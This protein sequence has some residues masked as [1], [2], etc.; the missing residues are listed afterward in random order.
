MQLQENIKIARL[1]GRVTALRDHETGK[2]NLEVAYL[3]GLFGQLLEL[4][5]PSL[6]ALMKGAFLHDIGKIGIPDKILLK[7]GGFNDE[8]WKIMKEHPILGSE[9]LAEMEWYKDANDV[10]LHHHEKFDGS[11]YPDGLAGYEIPY[12]ARI[13]TIIDVFDALCTKRPY[14]HPYAFSDTMK[15]MRAQ[16]GTYFDPEIF[17]IFETV[18]K[19]FFKIVHEDTEEELHVKLEHMRKKIFGA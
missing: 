16:N 18:A 14:K 5:I 10:V 1:L 6:Q 9:L 15:I 12:I 17:A 19:E 7:N 2:H 11:G 4:D 13:F 8:E 3:S